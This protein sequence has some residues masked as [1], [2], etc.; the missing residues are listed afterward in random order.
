[1]QFHFL[2]L[3]HD[4]VVGAHSEFNVIA[5]RLAAILYWKG[6][7]CGKGL[8]IIFQGVKCAKGTRKKKKH[9]LSKIT[10]AL[11]NSQGSVHDITVD[12]IEKFPKC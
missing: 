11:V 7:V 8:G 12:F 9:G 4:S 1:M 10:T 6:N 3:A 2:K 5:K